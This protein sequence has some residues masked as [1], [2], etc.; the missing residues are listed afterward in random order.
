M[1]HS[2]WPHELQHIRLP[3]PSLSSRVCSNSYPMSQWCHSAISS[4]VTLYPPALNLSQH[5]GL[6][7]WGS[8]S[9]QVAKV[10]DFQLQHSLELMNIQGWFP[11]GLSGLISLLSEGLSRV[12]CTRVFE[13]IYYGS[14]I[15]VHWQTNA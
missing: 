7:Q 8:S 11:L 2:L 12:F 10:L 14:N 1:S 13:S 9:H 15:D 3:Y 5:Q 4:S 6:F